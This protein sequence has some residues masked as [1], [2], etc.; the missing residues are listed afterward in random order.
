M[1]HILTFFVIFILI[2]CGESTAMK[3]EKPSYYIKLNM[4]NC[5]R[6]LTVNGIEIERDFAG[7]TSYG[8][9]P[10]NHYIKNGENSVEFLVGEKDY[11]LENVNENSK[12]IVEVR[13]RGKINGQGVD[14]KVADI[15]YSPNYTGDVKDLYASSMASGAY[16]FENN[17]EVKLNSKSP[18]FS[19]G[20]ITLAPLYYEGA[21]HIF[22]RTFTVSVPFPEW[23]FFSAEKVFDIP[24][25]EAQYD[26]YES[27]LLPELRSL[28]SLFAKKDLN[29][30]LPKFELRSKEVD[31]AFY[32]EPGTTQSELKVGLEN[33]FNNEFYLEPI[34]DEY[35]Q[36]LISYDGRL[37][38]LLN[39]ADM[40][41]SIIYRDGDGGGYTF[42]SIY[43]MKKDGKWVIAR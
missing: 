33:V 18:D 9:Y 4:V 11:M 5:P 21:G 35:L 41:G 17:N 31:M 43:W 28:E 38:A 19:V 6:L 1:K 30:I 8:E 20:D 13:V 34:E 27:Q 7:D 36:L 29:S 2:G 42:Y 12:G 3:I 25:S 39:A 40:A 23:S 24:Y 26:K 22:R 37:S 14:Y 15:N 32:K 10:I 16:S